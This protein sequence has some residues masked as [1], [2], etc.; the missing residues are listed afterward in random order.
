MSR[1]VHALHTC[2][3]MACLSALDS[4]FFVCGAWAEGN[5]VERA[6]PHFWCTERDRILM[7]LMPLPSL[8]AQFPHRLTSCTISAALDWKVAKEVLVF[9]LWCC[10]W[11]PVANDLPYAGCGKVSVLWGPSPERTLLGL[12]W[13]GSELLV[14]TLPVLVGSL[15][16]AQLS[17][18]EV[19]DCHKGDARS[20]LHQQR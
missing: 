17:L 4:Y 7:S 16:P 1:H 20:L 10:W 8:G 12:L 13:Q 18:A 2:S 15:G 11:L 5:K 9:D 6:A 3:L 14:W 19:Y